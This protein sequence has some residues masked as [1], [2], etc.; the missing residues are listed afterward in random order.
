[1]ATNT[2]VNAKQRNIG[3]SAVTV[4]TCSG[5]G[6]KSVVIGLRVTNTTA[7]SVN[8]SVKIVSSALDYYLVGWPTATADLASGGSMIIVN[9]DIDKVVLLDGERIDVFSNTVTSVDSVCSALEITP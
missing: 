2:F 6:K 9:G 8:I 1:M 4:Y 5:T 7:S 3:T